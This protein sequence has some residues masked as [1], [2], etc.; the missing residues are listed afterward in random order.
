MIYEGKD[1]SADIKESAEV[2]VIG[3]GA[4]GPVA[5][6]E[7][8]EKGHSVVMLEEGPNV[9]TEEFT[10]DVITTFRRY[11]RDGGATVGLGRPAVPF[12]IGRC[13]GGTTTVNSGTCFR[14][15]DRLLQKWMSEVGLPD[16]EPE[17]MRPYFERV[18]KIIDANPVTP[19]ILGK[20]G[21]IVLRGARQLGYSCGPLTRNIRGCRGC[22]VC[23]LGCPSGGKRA[24]FLNYIPMAGH[25]GAKVFCDARVDRIV[26]KDGKAAG[27]EGVILDR[28]QS[29][30]RR[31][32]SV[33]AKLVVLAAGA[34][35]SPLLLLKNGLANS[36]GEVGKNLRLHPGIRVYA[37][38]DEEVEGWS[39]V[40]QA[41]YVD[42]FADE[43]VMIEG[44]FVGPVLTAPALPFFGARHKELMFNYRR[45][46]SHG[47]MIHDETRGRVRRG[48]WGR[49]F[50][51]YQMIRADVNKAKKAIAETAR[52]YFAAGARKVYPTVSWMPEMTSPKQVDELLQADVRGPELEVMAFH[53]MGTCR[54][55]VN[56][57]D[58]V[59]DPYGESWDVKNLF[60]CDASIFPTCLGVNPMESIMAFANRSAD[61]IHAQKLKG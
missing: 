12:P 23:T 33:S 55:G 28:D 17:K 43:G 25:F 8:A 46:A 34:V 9:R 13:L 35:H 61:Y 21:E 2:V 4:G 3:S 29:K 38:M 32:F 15:P 39:G 18:E 41:V 24:T 20:N 5:A 58:S 22:G 54:M 56:R 44:V 45:L 57:A 30:P 50:I 36:S 37:L 60:A 26:V 49:P 7:L 31:R 19:D 10:R 1:F 11:Y 48:L 59:V 42:Q 27:V 52:I 16:I 40:P 51:T 14:T 6:K 47:A 53:P